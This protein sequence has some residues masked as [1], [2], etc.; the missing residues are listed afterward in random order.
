MHLV[1]TPLKEQNSAND[2]SSHP[3]KLSSDFVVL[4]CLS[5]LLRNEEQNVRHCVYTCTLTLGVRHSVCTSV[6]SNS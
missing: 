1:V 4:Y 5:V 2:T 6:H 3:P